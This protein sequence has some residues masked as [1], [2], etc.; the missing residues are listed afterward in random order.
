MKSGTAAKDRLLIVLGNDN[1]FYSTGGGR[2]PVDNCPK[3]KHSIYGLLNVR[4]NNHLRFST[5]PELI[6]YGHIEDPEY[7]KKA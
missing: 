4:T 5:P 2:K 1:W 3:E 7:H 6:L